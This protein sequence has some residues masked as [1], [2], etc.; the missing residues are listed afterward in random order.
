M[1]R[2]HRFTLGLTLLNLVLLALLVL[3][4]ARTALARQSVVPVLRARALEIV[5]AQ[6]RIRANILVHGPETVNGVTYPESVLFRLI[7]PTGGPLVKLTA[8]PNGSALGLSDGLSGNGGVQLYARDTAS[9]VR[10]VD[11]SGRAQMLKP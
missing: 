4:Q 7:D 3:S 1:P 5:D 2:I 11:K 6:G 8:A 10:I 9:F